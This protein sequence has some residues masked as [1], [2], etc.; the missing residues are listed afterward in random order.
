MSRRT[1]DDVADDLYNVLLNADK[2]IDAQRERDRDAD[3]RAGKLA[4]AHRDGYREIARAIETGLRGIA[5]AV[6]DSRR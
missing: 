4:Q 5:D 2:F 3:D 1:I 6:R